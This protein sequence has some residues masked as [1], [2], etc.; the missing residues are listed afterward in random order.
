MH[1]VESRTKE[2]DDGLRAELINRI[3]RVEH[4]EYKV[5][6]DNDTKRQDE[7]LQMLGQ[8][9][10]NKE[11]ETKDIVNL[12]ERILSL[13]GEV[14]EIRGSLAGSANIRTT[15]DHIQQEIDDIIRKPVVQV[16]ATAP[17]Q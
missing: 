9:K 17:H 8:T 16:P 13:R 12:N 4:E 6:K 2:A 14:K 5:R 1:Q 11:D 7:T 3:T 10:I 15:I